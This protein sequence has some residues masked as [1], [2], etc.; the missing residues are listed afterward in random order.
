M[1][2]H[3]LVKQSFVFL[4]TQFFQTLFLDVAAS[5]L[6]CYK[7]SSKRDL[8]G[9]FLNQGTSDERSY[10]PASCVTACKGKGFVY[11]AVQDRGQCFCGDSYGKYGKTPESDCNR[12]CKKDESE[13]CGGPWRNNVYKT[14]NPITFDGPTETC[15]W[16][17]VFSQTEATDFFKNSGCALNDCKAVLNSENFIDFNPIHNFESFE[18]GFRWDD[19]ETMRWRQNENPLIK[20]NTDMDPTDILYSNPV[21]NTMSYIFEGLS[22]STQSTT[23][24]DGVSSKNWWWYSV[25]F[26][27]NHT[28]FE[29]SGNPGY[30]SGSKNHP[31]V[32]ATEKTELFARNCPLPLSDLYAGCYKD[33]SK[34]D[35]N[36][37]FLSQGTKDERSYTPATCVQACKDLGYAFAAVQDR[38]QCFCDDSF[39]KYGRVSESE[40]NSFCNSDEF[41][42][43]GGKWRNN[44]YETGN[45]K[46]DLN[47]GCKWT[48]VYNQVGP[49]SFAKADC[50]FASCNT[51]V[52]NRNFIDFD[53]IKSF[54]EFEFTLRWDKDETMSWIQRENPL[55][56]TR[57]VF[58]LNYFLNLP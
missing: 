34:R 54:K 51:F 44:V 58:I 24:I 19:R 15:K 35:L 45:P 2:F 4:P 28:Q 32:I 39:G 25:G 6:G 49:S 57:I 3:K 23:F 30:S 18:F 36:G 33:S 1:V 9:D 52:D 22:I 50:T 55:S 46:P 27:R 21:A 31:F 5:Y 40:C 12:P 8:D 47:I 20:T 11:A 7:D 10:T 29:I 56:K 41:E 17:K 16:Q 14:G 26:T 37:E 13:T 43:C 38:G 48:K 42:T 53:S